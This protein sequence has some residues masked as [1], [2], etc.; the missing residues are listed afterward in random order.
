MVAPSAMQT[1]P[2]PPTLAA[3]PLEQGAPETVPP[4]RAGR[5]YDS[6]WAAR[7]LQALDK[8]GAEDAAEAARATPAA[9]ADGRG[10]PPGGEG[11]KLAFSTCLQRSASM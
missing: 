4:A 3:V 7:M 5:L 2:Q 10:G 6:S 1:A 11:A 9:D 8:R